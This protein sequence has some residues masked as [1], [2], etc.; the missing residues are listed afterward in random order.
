MQPLSTVLPN[1]TN[2]LIDT[3]C[4]YIASWVHVVTSVF[5]TLALFTS[6]FV[7]RMISMCQMNIF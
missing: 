1:K 7:R 3:S 4:T 6:T 2:I 5:P